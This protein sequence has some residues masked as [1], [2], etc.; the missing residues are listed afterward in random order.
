MRRVRVP[1]YLA[2]LSL[3]MQSRRMLPQ[4]SAVS[5]LLYLHTQVKT[6]VSAGGFCCLRGTPL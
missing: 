6:I 2:M 3:R 4:L 5:A 1:A